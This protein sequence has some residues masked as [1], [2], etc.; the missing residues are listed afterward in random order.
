MAKQT[1][2][3]AAD[4][5]RIVLDYRSGVSQQDL[6]KKYGCHRDN[7]RRW[8]NSYDGTLESL[9]NG[10]SVPLTP[11]PDAHTKEEKTWIEDAIAKNNNCGIDRLHE[12]LKN[13]YGYTRTAT[14]LYR[15]VEK[16]G[17]LDQALTK[18][19]KYSKFSTD[20]EKN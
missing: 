1:R 17:L 8:N 4:K 15:F 7:I 2:L 11:H 14:G 19:Y 20:A 6:C 9:E 13:Q 16:C 18:E 10:S 12:I 3:T 5:E